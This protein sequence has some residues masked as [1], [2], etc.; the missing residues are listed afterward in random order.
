LYS[1]SSPYSLSYRGV[2]KLVVRM[3][4]RITQYSVLVMGHELSKGVSSARLVRKQLNIFG[5]ISFYSVVLPGHLAQQN[6]GDHGWLIQTL[7]S[8]VKQGMLVQPDADTCTP[9]HTL[10]IR[11][12]AER[13]ANVVDLECQW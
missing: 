2:N 4:R 7:M 9:G 8:T 1:H 11:Y 10:S 6:G 5:N 12:A 3:P 13:A